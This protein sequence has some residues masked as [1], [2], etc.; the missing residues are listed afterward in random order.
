MKKMTL[1]T[2]FLS[3]FVILSCSNQEQTSQEELTS[4]T[5][6]TATEQKYDELYGIQMYYLSTE[7][8]ITRLGLLKTKLVAELEKGN[9]EVINQLE[10]IQKEI[11]KLTRFNDYL[12]LLKPAK[13]LKPLPPPQPCL[14]TGNCDPTKKISSNTLIILGKELAITKVV[15]KNSKNQSLDISFQP[16]EDS[17]GQNALQV[18]TNYNGEG[19]MYT[20]IKTKVVGEITIPTPVIS[21]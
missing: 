3:A 5:A 10:N 15:V 2:L 8:E 20:T 17:F 9:K 13:G 21:L 16:V 11:E 1:F 4:I 12:I 19:V 14:E 18:S 6:K 7:A